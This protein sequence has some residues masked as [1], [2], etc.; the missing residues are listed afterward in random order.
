MNNEKDI[1]LKLT[2]LMGLIKG[3]HYLAGIKL[4]MSIYRDYTLEDISKANRQVHR[5]DFTL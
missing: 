5:I 2:G 3:H 1:L 4:F